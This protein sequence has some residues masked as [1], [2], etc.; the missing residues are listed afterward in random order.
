MRNR[1]PVLEDNHSGGDFRRAVLRALSL[2][3]SLFMSTREKRYILISSQLTPTYFHLLVKKYELNE[4]TN[5]TP[6]QFKAYNRALALSLSQSADKT[7]IK[8]T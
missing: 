1:E 5:K 4:F 2:S 6:D 8:R 7:T 3:H